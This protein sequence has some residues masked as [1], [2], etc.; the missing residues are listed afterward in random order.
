MKESPE[1]RHGDVLNPE[2]EHMAGIQRARAMRELEEESEDEEDI[3][4]REI[5][6]RV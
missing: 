5:L 6:E 1:K 4:F 2:E 3:E